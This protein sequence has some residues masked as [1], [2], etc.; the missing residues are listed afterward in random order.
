MSPEEWNYCEK[1]KSKFSLQCHPQCFG[2]DPRR[3][4]DLKYEF[5]RRIHGNF[6][7]TNYSAAKAGMIAFTKTLA[8]EIGKNKITVNAVAPV[9]SRLQ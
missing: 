7:Q 2:I 1:C 9:L 8:K 4:Q 5:H 3:R 6:G